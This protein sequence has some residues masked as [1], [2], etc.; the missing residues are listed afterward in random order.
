VNIGVA[1]D[2]AQ[3]DLAV[4]V[5]LNGT[6]FFQRAVLQL[7]LGSG[8]LILLTFI[9]SR[10]GLNV[11]TVGFAYLIL[12]ALLCVM[13]SFVVSVVLSFVA[14]ACLSYFFAP[15]L[16]TLRVD[17]PEDIFAIAAFLTTSIIIT[18]LAARARRTA[19]QTLAS[20]NA[21]VDTIPAMVWS[22]TP[23]G[24]RDFHSQRWLDF[25]GLS[26]QEATGKS[27]AATLY[28]EDRPAVMEKWQLAVTTGKPFEVEA[29]ARGAN[30][31]YRWF[32][33]RAEPLR[34]ERG[35]IVKWYGTST[36]IED[37]KRAIEALRESEEQW[38][39]VFEH[40][41]VMYFMIDPDGTVLS[42]NTF[43]AAQLGYAVN[44]LIGQSVLNVFFEE[45]RAAVQ[46]NVAVCLET[47][48][49]SH[50]W[51]IRKAR[52]DGRVLW[53]RENAKAVRRSDNQLIVLIA[54]EDITDSKKTGDALRLSEAYMAHAQ[55]LA[56]VGSWAYKPPGVCEHWSAEMFRML[57]FDPEKG[58]P[59]NEEAASRVHPEDRQRADEA[60]AGLFEHGQVFNTK[61][62]Y[63]LPDGQL[64][65][66]RDFGTPIFENG[67]ITRFVG[68]CLD[69]TEQE[70]LTEELRLKERELQTLINSIPAY[71]GSAEPDGKVDFISDPWLKY[72]G[73]TKEDWVGP[74]WKSIL[75]PDDFERNVNG[76]L[77]ALAAGQPF[78]SDARYRRADGEFVWFNSHTEPRR[79]ET[80]R[81]VKWYGT[82]FNIDDR[83][84]AEEALRLSEVYMAHA[85]QLAGFGSWAYKSSHIGG[86][87]DVCEHWSPEM[88]RIAGFDPSE[89][90][91][92]TELIFSRIHPEDLQPMID[93]N[94]QVINDDRPLNIK[95]RYFH[96]DGQLRVLHSFGTLLREDGI[97]SRFVGATIDITDQEQRLEALRQSELYLA[98]GQRLAHQGSWSFNPAGYYDFWS[99]ELFRVYGFDP[100]Q[101]APTL[102]QYLSAVHPEDREFMSR[103]IQEM[104]AQGLGCDVTKRIAR[105]D[106]EVRYIRCV[107]VPVL[108]KGIL[109]SI[110]GTAIDVTEQEHLTQELRR[111][112]A[113]LAEAQKL[114]RTGS[115]GWNVAS[116]EIF[117]SEET[118]RIFECDKS[119]TPSLE[120]V[121]QRTHPEDRAVVQK[122]HERVRDE[123]KD[124]DF[125]HRL[126]TPDGSTKYVHAVAR[127]AKNA[128]GALEFVGAVM[129]ITAARRAD[130]E[131][132][133]TR[134]QL[135][136]FARLTTLGELT[137]SIAHEVNQPLSG[138]IN[139]ANAGVRWLDSQPPDIHRARQSID[140]I[141]RDAGRASEVVA[142]VRDLAKKTPPR[143]GWLNINETVEEIISLTRQEVRKNHVW[144]KTQLSDDVPPI[145]ADR[146][147][148][149]QVILNLIINAVEALTAVPDAE[150]VLQITTTAD[151][152]G[153]VSLTVGDSGP[154][155][156]QE[157]L[158]EIFGAFY[159]T[160]PDGMG[161]G[162][163]VS[164][165]I[166]E[167]HGGRLWAN[168]N[169]PRGA[170]FQ[171]TLPKDQG[172]NL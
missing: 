113:Y 110:F 145:L 158:E 26:A 85:Q 151:P 12:V 160:K 84:R 23:D 129:D 81:I 95:Y 161:M 27:W 55:E 46:R 74:G 37:R 154:G 72:L 78:V 105:P 118:F 52:K 114:S 168:K 43:G 35:T 82:H 171:F 24:S 14:I 149:Q 56:R 117:W 137:A 10:A 11:P 79:D 153:D 5:K 134:T 48:G 57:G 49:V 34:D 89:G 39:Q 4:Q 127:A 47:L 139:S 135:T 91:P 80:G 115:F 96:A 124:W 42:V 17:A 138:V 2:I 1:P 142:R 7:F 67:V 128:L 157:K 9:C 76:W 162:L 112:E 108:N 70:K 159:T 97:A 143:K 116:G 120:L 66:I 144:L 32:L 71:I 164:R 30:G 170:I 130:E 16:Y 50:G 65:V 169:E 107:G 15:P 111:R 165:S 90:Y 40:N 73:V 45:D 75:H 87:W 13:G 59:N 63:I 172:E 136:H 18:S 51:E 83:K 93:A 98:E 61:Y 86:Y 88:W 119:V 77:G 101:G 99:E 58:Y 163:A 106:G 20:K 60:L 147:Q 125:E 121:L 69:V 132:H 141:I 31:Q 41:P 38:R 29:R 103:T 92:P 148:L 44:E 123:G 36:D 104:V 133:Q 126:L 8:G 22:A 150:R 68:A 25:T 21:L 109:K 146:I 3:R 64:R 152:S 166:I 100:A 28:V 94:A 156:D 155:L 54:C 33:L 131:L 122:F 167:A 6:S 102:E 62:R 19:D 140:R 53:V